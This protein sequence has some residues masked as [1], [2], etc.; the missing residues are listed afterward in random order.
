VKEI[1]MNKFQLYG[2]VCSHIGNQLI[3]DFPAEPSDWIYIVGN[4]FSLPEFSE[5]YIDVVN[6][7]E[8]KLYPPTVLSIAQEINAEGLQ[9]YADIATLAVIADHTSLCLDPY[10]LMKTCYYLQENL[11]KGV[12][13]KDWIQHRVHVSIN[14]LLTTQRVWFEKHFKSMFDLFLSVKPVVAT[15]V[16]PPTQLPRTKS[17]K[18]YRP[19]EEFYPLGSGTFGSVVLARRNE[20]FVAIKTQDI[21]EETAPIVELSVLA[22]YKH[23]NII[24]MLD[25]YL[26]DTVLEIDLES[27]QSFYDVLYQVEVPGGRKQLWYETFIE[28]VVT[29]PLI[30]QEQR[31][32]YQREICR[33]VEYLHSMGIIHR[34]L[35]PQ[36]ILLVGDT[37][38]IADFGLAYQMCLSYNDSSR[39]STN[40]A[41]IFY[42]PPEILVI[43][44]NAGNEDLASQYAF[45]LDFLLNLFR[46]YN[47]YRVFDPVLGSRSYVVRN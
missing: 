39:K 9:V 15:L 31:R 24:R 35:K 40:V 25:F 30:P 4:A 28:G 36:N 13:P 47:L 20:E 33:G 44:E 26:T 38:K 8:G 22:T 45:N 17:E 29:A 10:I 14:H 5:T 16:H 32:R 34:D 1:P 2:C 37:I 6:L 11:E 19:Y 3:M 27:G 46:G 43:D 41:T 23:E 18:L 12:A 42:R 7:L 21:E